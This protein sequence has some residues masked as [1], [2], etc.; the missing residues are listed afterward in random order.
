MKRAQILVVGARLGGLA[1]ARAQG[2]AGLAP[3]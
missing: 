1:L 2:E 3:R